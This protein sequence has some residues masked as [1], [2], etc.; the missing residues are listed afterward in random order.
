MWSIAEKIEGD[1]LSSLTAAAKLYFDAE[2][3]LFDRITGISGVLKPLPP[4]QRRA[5]IATELHRMEIERSDLYLPIDRLAKLVNIYKD[6]GRA[7]QS[8]AK[9]PIM[10]KFE[11]LREGKMS[12]KACIFKVG[13]DCRQDV[14][15]LQVIE[16]LKDGYS[17]AGL[18]ASLQ[19]YGCIATGFEQ[20]II[21]VVPN[22]ASRDGIGKEM[23]GGL[24]DMFRATFGAVGS[25]SF[26]RA[27]HNFLLSCAGYAVA[28]YILWSKDRHNGNILLANDGSIVH[29][30]FGYILGISPGGNLGFETAAFKFSYEMKELLDPSQDQRSEIFKEFAALVIRCYLVARSHRE[31]IYNVVA[32]QQESGLPCFGYGKPLE[33]LRER[34]TP[35]LDDVA[36]AQHMYKKI[37]H[38]YSTKT[39]WGYDVIQQLQ[40]GIQH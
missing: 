9:T 35:D 8:A 34:L 25:P 23:D 39:T 10:V 20:G 3:G 38:A 2:D 7:M 11:V 15:A 21:E 36:A 5:R 30:D 32:L 17:A 19:P 37:Q 1:V 12:P 4:A 14:L 13:D 26:E 24:L 27:R 28:S 29:I 33:F 40:Q 16:I 31:A 22:T 18:P 6:S